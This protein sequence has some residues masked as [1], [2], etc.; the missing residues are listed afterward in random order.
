MCLSICITAPPP[1]TVIHI[2]VTSMKQRSPEK[3]SVS[4]LV[5]KYSTFYGIQHLVSVLTQARHLHLSCK[6]EIHF[7]PFHLISLRSILILFY[8]LFLGLSI[9]LFPLN[10]L[11]KHYVFLFTFEALKSW[12]S[13]LCNFLH[14]PVTFDLSDPKISSSAPCSGTHSKYG[15]HLRDESSCK[16]L[17]LLFYANIRVWRCIIQSQT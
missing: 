10:S 16:N 5:K 9:C 15:L 8:R 6:L 3:L 12:S 2:Y 14:P 17:I 1:Q 4:R 7:T 13:F 11:P